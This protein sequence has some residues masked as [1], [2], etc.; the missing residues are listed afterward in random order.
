[1][2]QHPTLKKSSSIGAKKSVLKRYDRIKL[3]K[4]RGEW[5]EGMSPIGLPKTKPDA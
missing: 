3:L 4:A 2:S 1:M 5:K